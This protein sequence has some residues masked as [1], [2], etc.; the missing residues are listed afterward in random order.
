MDVRRA[1]FSAVT[2]RGFWSLL[3]FLIYLDVSNLVCWIF[4]VVPTVY[5]VVGLEALFLCLSFL[6]VVAMVGAGV[7]VFCFVEVLVAIRCKAWLLTWVTLAG[8]CS[9]FLLGFV[10][11]LV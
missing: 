6:V 5:G 1:V 8:R 7:G 4:F 2:G 9:N 11:F 3:F 10:W